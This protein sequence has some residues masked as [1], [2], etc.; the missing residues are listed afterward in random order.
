[1]VGR[2]GDTGKYPESLGDDSSGVLVIVELKNQKYL[3]SD[4]SSNLFALADVCIEYTSDQ[5]EYIIRT[6][7]IGSYG[8]LGVASIKIKH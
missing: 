1:M 3:S 8:D 6:E 2:F 5:G 4:H 7:K